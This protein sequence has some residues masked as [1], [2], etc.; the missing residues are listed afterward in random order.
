MHY[1]AVNLYIY[2]LVQI[3]ID[4]FSWEITSYTEGGGDMCSH[5]IYYIINSNTFVYFKFG[6]LFYR[7]DIC[8]VW[9]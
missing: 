7:D 8:F 9:K 6:I 4:L 2:V 3:A 1:D 5:T